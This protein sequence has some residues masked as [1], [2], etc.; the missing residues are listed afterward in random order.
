MSE[1]I[2]SIDLRVISVQIVK[3][4]VLF[5][6]DDGIFP[7]SL[8]QEIFLGFLLHVRYCLGP[9]D[10]AVAPAERVP[11]LW[12]QPLWLDHWDRLRN[13]SYEL[14]SETA[15][16]KRLFSSCR[17]VMFDKL[18]SLSRG[19][20]HNLIFVYCSGFLVYLITLRLWGKKKELNSP[21]QAFP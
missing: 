18:A 13:I 10:E 2:F 21:I 17:E 11:T 16:M 6:R 5:K 15:E 14:L 9:G 19:R 12:T 1:W 20:K 8:I 4:Y 3:S 7:C